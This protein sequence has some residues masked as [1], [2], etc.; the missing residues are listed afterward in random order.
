[1]SEYLESTQSMEWTIPNAIQGDACYIFLSLL[2]F[3]ILEK[4]RGFV[5]TQY[6]NARNDT[7]KKVRL[8]LKF[9]ELT[10]PQMIRSPISELPSIYS[11]FVV[12][13]E[14]S[15]YLREEEIV[16]R[17][18]SHL[19]RTR[20]GDG[21][22]C[23]IRTSWKVVVSAFNMFRKAFTS[24]AQNTAIAY[25]RRFYLYNNLRSFNPTIVM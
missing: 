14:L 2:S 10:S 11:N 20:C 3:K 24:I 21:E 4:I 8:L 7:E 18:F 16:I 1:M 6:N 19:M 25:F 23:K 17:H 13:S 15:E 12:S 5:Y 22:K 9:C